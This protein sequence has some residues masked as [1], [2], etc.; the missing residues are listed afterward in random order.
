MELDPNPKAVNILEVADRRRPGRADHVSSELIGL[1]RGTA[2]AGSVA[3][4]DTDVFTGEDN[5]THPLSGGRSIVM[6]LLFAAP[7]W[8]LLGSVVWILF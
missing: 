5:G 4:E 8:A 6:G 3:P 2:D 7:F 1:L